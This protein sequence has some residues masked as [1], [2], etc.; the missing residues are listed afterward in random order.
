MASPSLARSTVLLTLSGCVEFSLQLLVPMIFVRHLDPATFGQYRL[1]W[2]MAGTALAIAPAFLPQSL[3]YFLPRADDQGQRVLIGNVLAYLGAAGCVVA[4][5]ASTANPFL[6]THVRSLYD[7]SHGR[8]ALFLG[9]WL[10]VTLMNTLPTAEGRIRW[11]AGADIAMSLLR[12]ALLAAAAIFTHQLAWVTAALML[13]VLARFGLMAAY[14]LTRP[15]GGRIGFQPRALLAQLRYGLPFAAGNSLFG[16]RLQADQWVAASLLPSALFGMFT[17]GAVL[18]PLASLVRQPFN[19]AMMPHLN[20]AFAEGRLDDIR[21]LFAKSS[22]AQSLL[23]LPLAGALFCAAE[24]LVQVVYTG[25]YAAA[26]PVMQIYLLGMMMHGCAAGHLLPALNQG[27]VA[28]LNNACCLLLSVTCSYLGARTWGMIGAACGSVF[29][30]VASEL[31]S[32]AVVART[33]AIRPLDLLPLRALA[34][35]LLATASAMIG[36]NLL[37]PALHAPA[38][39]VLVIKG[40]AFL[41]LFTAVFFGAGGKAHL[42]ALRGAGQRQPEAAP[43]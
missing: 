30:F 1:L 32:L 21:N 16:M 7:A 40:V 3:F 35:T 25:R 15:G 12:T 41:V 4:L 10:V 33:L 11:Q 43:A 2:L 34:T 42:Q 36:V 24:Q 19:N 13:D 23:L 29:A 26:V 17:I 39:L 28:V 38:L 22:A 27:R 5:L 31:W 8:S 18:L 20:K 6:P 14:L 9:C 37:Q